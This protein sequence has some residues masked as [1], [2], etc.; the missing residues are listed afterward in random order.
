[1]SVEVAA[2]TKLGDFALDAAFASEGRTTALFGRSGSGKTSLVNVIAG[3]LRPAEGRVAVD[4]TVL[5][6]SEAGINVPAHRR[7]IGYVFQEAR[8]FPHLTVRN[9]LL[10]GRWFAPEE[11]RHASLDDVVE[12]LGLEDLLERGTAQLS[13][14]E[15]QRVAIGR[16]LLCSPRLLLMDEP[17]ASLDDTRK[18]EVMPFLERLRDHAR[19]PIVYVSHSV[20]EVVRLATTLVLMSEGRVAASGPTADVMGRIDLFPVTGP[21]EAGAVIHGTVEAH[22]TTADLTLVTSRAGL[23]RVPGLDLAPGTQIRMRV[24]ARDVMIAIKA[25]EGL[26]ALN[27]LPGRVVEVGPLQ[28]PVV[29]IALDCGGERLLAE[30]TRHSVEALQLRPGREVFALIKSVTFDQVSDISGPG[31]APDARTK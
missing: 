17:L 31:C 4:G 8:L 3:L 20:P 15:K 16:A 5:F 26:S 6:D 28:G 2:R 27:V 10:Y 1:M 11:S 14:G 24:R 18:G 22:D 23:L 9:N 25:P 30:L 29:D 13:G 7:R 12:L 19:V 21:V